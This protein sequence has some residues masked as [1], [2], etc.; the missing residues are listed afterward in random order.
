MFLTQHKYQAE[1]SEC[2]G[3]GRAP[4]GVIRSI[5]RYILK[6]DEEELPLE[7]HVFGVTNSQ[8]EAESKYAGER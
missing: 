5:R 6:D 4:R 1:E 8:T 2:G 7:D 3:K